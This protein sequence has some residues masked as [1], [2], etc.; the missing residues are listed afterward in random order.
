MAGKKQDGP[1][2]AALAAGSTVAQAAQRAD[3][4]VRTVARRLACPAFRQ[5]VADAQREVVAR[6]TARLAGAST[7]AATTLR[8]LLRS[9]DERVQL[10]A[11][12]AVLKMLVE[13]QTHSDFDERIAALEA[14]LLD[15]GNT[16]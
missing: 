5:A 11:A 2:I 4:S 8:R 13:M 9:G 3:C 15:G 10:S 6:A 1:L 12:Q 14:K 16:P 7:A